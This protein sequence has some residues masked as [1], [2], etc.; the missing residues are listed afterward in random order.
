M[1]VV[2]SNL[3]NHKTNLINIK[4]TINKINYSGIIEGEIKDVIKNLKDVINTQIISKKTELDYYIREEY[5][6]YMPSPFSHSNSL[7]YIIPSILY[8]IQTYNKK[9]IIFKICFF[10]NSKQFYFLDINKY[11]IYDIEIINLNKL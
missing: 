4:Y 9:K 11:P 2:K 6:D 8:N 1:N 10:S 3:S 7:D 5:G